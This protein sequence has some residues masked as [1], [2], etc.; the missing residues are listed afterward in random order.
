MNGGI[1]MK[2]YCS[3]LLA[4]SLVLVPVLA[5]AAQFAI[6]GPRAL[7]MGG[8]SVAAVNDSTAV[9]WN[10]AAL[11]N[12]RKVDIRIPGGVAVRDYIELNDNWD[13]INA[14]YDSFTAV[15]Q[16]EV[17]ELKQLLLDMDRPGSV[18]N[19]DVT[20]G[21][22]VS[23][24]VSS[25]AMAISVPVIGYAE[26]LPT[27]DTLNLGTTL[28]APS[29]ENNNSA[30]TAVGLVLV[31]PAVSFATS[32]GDHFLVGAN[33]KMIY[34]ST[35]LHSDIIQTGNFDNFQDDMD[36][37]ETKSNK[38][39]I[40]AGILFK[41]TAGLDVGVVGRYL[42]SPSFPIAGSVAVKDG[43]GD[44]SLAA[45]SGQEIE[46][47][48]Q[49]RAGVAWKPIDNLTL[50]ADY[51]LSKNKSF[52]ENTEDQTIAGGLELTLLSEVL[53][54]RAGAYKN[55]ANDLANIVYTAGLGFRIF[56]LRFDVAG[57]YDFKEQ[58][59]QAAASLALS[60]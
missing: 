48:P 49:Y 14:I 18:T 37:S 36:R 55:T 3:V 4:L 40:D 57:A 43:A 22:L 45:A 13:R 10:P 15:S 60:F 38:G 17:D 29:I 51:D 20:G 41:P 34:A 12:S 21:L 8:A 46:L 56:A 26:I 27:I 53:S 6:L 19:I 33:V 59:A 39:S 32:L 30:V 44:V 23:F 42:N 11:A 9:Y 35:F 52:T 5:Q 2:R 28:P 24:P 58:E 16:A 54:L 50:S 25:S 1:A 7:G 31:E 47:K